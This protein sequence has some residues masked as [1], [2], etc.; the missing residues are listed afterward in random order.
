M[1]NNIVKGLAVL[2]GLTALI[3]GALAW[4]YDATRERIDT[5]RNQA[6]WKEAES[7]ANDTTLRDYLERPTLTSSV[8]LQDD[9]RLGLA[10]TT[11]Y[12]GSIDLMILLNAD[13]SI[14]G[15]R[16]LRHAETPGIGDF[17]DGDTPIDGNTP[18]NG[19]TPWMR[20]F[21]GLD[22]TDLPDIDGRTGATITVDAIRQGVKTFVENSGGS[23]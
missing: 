13:G 10:R 15:V 2:L 16:T 3:V 5:N 23:A 9:R 7:L 17:I 1:T 14:A 6:F 21:R 12:G 11:G 4:V 22:A 8:R 18:I 19:N 20:Q